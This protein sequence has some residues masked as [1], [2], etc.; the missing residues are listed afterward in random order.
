[1]NQVANAA[2]LINFGL[3]FSAVIISLYLII[4]V[5]VSGNLNRKI[6]KYFFLMVLFNLIGSTSNF[7]LGCFIYFADYTPPFLF[8]ALDYIGFTAPGFQTF[9]FSLYIH[10][11]LKKKTRMSL[12]LVYISGFFTI[13][14]VI[15]MAVAFVNNKIILFENGVY[16]LSGSFWLWFIFPGLSFIAF[17]IAAI[18]YIKNFSLKERFAIFIYLILPIVFNILDMLYTDIYFGYFFSTFSMFIIYASIQ[19]ELKWQ[20]E[21]KESELT[22]NR[23]AIMQ[24]QIQP[25][26][27]YNS[28]NAISDLCYDNQE[29]NRALLSFSS[30]LRTN[31]D[32]LTDRG[33]I[34][35]E[36]E[37]KHTECYLY[38]EKLRFTNRLKVIYDIQ[39][40]DF[41]LPTLTLQPI[42][43]NAVR[44]GV[45]QKLKGGTVTIKTEELSDKYLIKVIDD[46]V[47]F[48]HVK[49][50]DRKTSHVGLINVKNR[51]AAMCGGS[52][53][54]DSGV[55]EG[56]AV[57]IE[58]PK[59]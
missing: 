36:N 42:V 57:T 51:L 19:V 44:H 49:T 12:K 15:L 3:N 30:Y 20:I 6:N 8:Y 14:H 1:M 32:S 39:A 7:V 16:M 40:T 46:G 33:L 23:I 11:Y 26:F 22:E 58:I 55:E 2:L 59:E 47:G 38:L 9:A 17:I 31:M 24:S 5:F 25:H 37:L 56:T 41:L 28:L 43:E 34:L 13:A 21:R 54:I 18:K 4:A 48:N 27:L 53:I 52:I 50:L 35:F 45:S 29:A 10:E